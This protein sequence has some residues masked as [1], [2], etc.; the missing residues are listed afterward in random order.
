[1]SDPACK[2]C[3]GFIQMVKRIYAAGGRVEASRVKIHWIHYS[4][5]RM[6]GADTTYYARETS[7]PSRYQTKANGP[8]AH[9]KGGTVTEILYLRKTAT[10]W[11]MLETAQL[12]DSYKPLRGAAS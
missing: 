3:A 10:G 2:S 12:A 7:Q 4:K 8:W 11:S 5:A 9:L 1:M 6:Y